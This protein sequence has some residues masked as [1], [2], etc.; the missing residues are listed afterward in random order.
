MSP[1]APTRT[2]QL[3]LVDK[4]IAS[5]MFR[6][7][8][9]PDRMPVLFALRDRLSP[10]AY[11]KLTRD[12]WTTS[13]SLFAD[14][15]LIPTL[16]THHPACARLF[17]NVAERRTLAAMPS[18]VP[19]FRGASPTNRNG[20]SWTLDRDTARFFARRS[21]ADEVGY[22][23][24]GRVDRDD[25]IGF[26]TGRN[27]VEIV[28]DPLN[29][30]SNLYTVLAPDDMNEGRH[31]YWLAQTGNLLPDLPLVFPLDG[32]DAFTAAYEGRIARLRAYDL[33]VLAD[34]EQVRL[35]GARFL[36]PVAGPEERA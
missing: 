4:E 13:E 6:D 21:V 5:L 9:K 11:W 35:D 30:R 31:L 16:L 24:E 12:V 34:R 22:V 8:D 7:V 14:E 32:E 1:L 3:T 29:V 23:Y 33:H 15:D 2:A 19:V 18:P 36:G 28:V 20:Y 10:A 27:E 17:M 26:L 25:V